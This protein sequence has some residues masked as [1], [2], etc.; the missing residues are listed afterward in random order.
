MGCTGADGV[1]D[2]NE[3]VERGEGHFERGHE[4]DDW[5]LAEKEHEDGGDD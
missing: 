5:D 1:E 4:E 3:F 2:Q